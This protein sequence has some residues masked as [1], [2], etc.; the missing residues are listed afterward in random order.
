MILCTQFSFVGHRFYGLVLLLCFVFSSFSIFSQTDRKNKKPKITGQRAL[1]V[2]QG[3]S[4]TIRLV[5]LTVEDPDDGLFY[6][7]GFTLKVYEGP[8][9]SISDNTVTPRA[10]FEGELTVKVTVNDG[11]DESDK[12]DLKITVT[13]S[14][15]RPRISGQQTISTNEDVPFELKTSHL[16]IEDPD[17]SEFALTVSEGEN[18]TVSGS[19]ITPALNFSGVLSIEVTVSD[20]QADSEPYDVQLTVN[21]VNDAPKI[22]GQQSISTNASSPVVIDLTHL[23]VEDPD[24]SYP[25]DFILLIRKG[26]NYTLNGNQLTP[27]TGFSG[28]LIADMSVNDG[29]TD[30]EVFHFIVSVGRGPSAPIITNQEPVIINEDES[31]NITLSDLHVA[32]EKNSYP[33][34][35]ALKI[36]GGDHYTINSSTVIPEKDFY[37][38]LFVKL[39]VNNGE[40]TSEPF[41]FQ[42]TVRPVND[43]P[44]L[45]LTDLDSLVL[46]SGAEA[47]S[48]FQNISI[49]D[50]DNDSLALAEIGFLPDDYIS[51]SDLLS[52]INT[53]KIK[54]VFDAASGVLA[55]IGKASLADYV[56]AIK[57][58]GISVLTKQQLATTVYVTVNDGLAS[59]GRAEKTVYIRNQNSSGDSVLEI[60]TGFTPN[61]DF[62]NDTWQ[63]QSGKNEGLYKQAIVRVYTRSGLMVYEANGLNKPWDGRYNGTVLPAD[64]YFYTIDLNI[65]AAQ[66]L[67]KG[68]VTILR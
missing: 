30:S 65:P 34:G 32:D 62:V 68:I 43:A 19:V 2:S 7:W 52:Y 55:L 9:Y 51:G 21:A 6:P 59:S 48:L 61:G 29:S 49:S 25:E 16:T 60:P 13:G 5:D 24:N 56:S 22:T 44:V 54:G 35:Y 28:D 42:I 10:D 14:N 33:N 11:K 36:S 41:N 37:G 67:L 53:G 40:L 31:F 12:F 20:G 63:I 8:N 15:D 23:T 50:V 38:N 27:N 17:D 66:P 3:Q 58:I 47:V 39:T 1:S 4:I 45:S 46:N 26:S 64:V 57:S 18:Y